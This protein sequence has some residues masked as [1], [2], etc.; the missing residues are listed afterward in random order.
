MSKKKYVKWILFFV[1]LYIFNIV[2]AKEIGEGDKNNGFQY[3]ESVAGFALAIKI[4]IKEI[5]LGHVV[6]A[7]VR[8]K[9]VSSKTIKILQTSPIS[10]FFFEITDSSGK[11]IPKLRYQH[12]LDKR[13]RGFGSFGR[14]NFCP[15]RAGQFVEHKFILSRRFDFSLKSKY[16]VRCHRELLLYDRQRINIQS[17]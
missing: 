12:E 10:Q 13:E 14:M 3:G 17:K 2:N 15:I 9:N 16:L 5:E 4:Q 7:I 6:Y 8:V 1:F 11:Q